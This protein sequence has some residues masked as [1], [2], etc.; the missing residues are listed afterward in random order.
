MYAKA[1]AIWQV[2]SNIKHEKDKILQG[3]KTSLLLAHT[4]SLF[5]LIYQKILAIEDYFIFMPW[6]EALCFRV[7]HP[8]IPFSW[9]W[10]LR[11][12]LREFLQNCHKRP[13][14]LKDELVQSWCSKVKVTVTSHLSH[15]HECDITNVHLDSRINWFE[16]GCQRSNVKV[17]V[18][19][20]K[21]F[22]AI[23]PEFIW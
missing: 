21:M 14:G 13:L 16:F 5:W 6:P 3:H 1:G 22:L 15:S 18:T 17:T 23:T 4:S 2:L 11:N 20:Q 12:A 19:S 9:T 10:Y 7:V 8:S